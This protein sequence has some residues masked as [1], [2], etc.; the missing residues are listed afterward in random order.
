MSP[1]T[2]T[3]WQ[4][5][6]SELKSFEVNKLIVRKNPDDKYGGNNEISHDPIVLAPQFLDFPN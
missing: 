2:E 5:F 3:I 6:H 4:E 1:T